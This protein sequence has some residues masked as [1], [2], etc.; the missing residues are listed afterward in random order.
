MSVT[1][2]NL[3]TSVL[4]DIDFNEGLSNIRFSGFA[5]ATLII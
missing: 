4:K 1:L 2:D 3:G 5:T